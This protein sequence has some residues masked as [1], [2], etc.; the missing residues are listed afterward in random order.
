MHEVIAQCLRNLEGHFRS[1]GMCYAL[2]RGG[3]EKYIQALLGFELFGS[4]GGNILTEVSMKGRLSI[5]FLGNHDGV[6][7]AIE[8]GVNALCNP[9]EN[10]LIN[11]I[12]DDVNKVLNNH[13]ARQVFTIS[14]LDSM[15]QCHAGRHLPFVKY[16]N[17]YRIPI[18]QQA[19]TEQLRHAIQSRKYFSHPSLQTVQHNTFSTVEFRGYQM[20]L[21]FLVCGPFVNPLTKWW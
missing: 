13:F 7:T 5:D 14:V 18:D 16:Q 11:H 3:Y 19:R 1:Q 12:I 21:H 8:M 20:E 9:R 6:L 15:C 2:L 10:G 4:T 17:R